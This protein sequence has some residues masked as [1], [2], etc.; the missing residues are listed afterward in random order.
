M[1]KEK[2]RKASK[3]KI[4]LLKYMVPANCIVQKL[5]HVCLT[6]RNFNAKS[7]FLYVI[8]ICDSSNAASFFSFGLFLSVV[9]HLSKILVNWTF[10]DI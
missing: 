7:A 6:S 5:S 1:K 2:L 10:S 9:C 3:Q 4:A 8:W